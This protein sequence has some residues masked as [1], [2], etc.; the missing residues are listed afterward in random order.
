MGFVISG[1]SPTSIP[2]KQSRTV[3]HPL[4]NRPIRLMIYG[5]P[6]GAERSA[7]GVGEG[8]RL[9][10]GPPEPL[11][12]RLRHYHPLK[13]SPLIILRPS[14]TN[15]RPAQVIGQSLPPRRATSPC[16][17]HAPPPQHL[18]EHPPTLPPPPTVFALPSVQTQADWWLGDDWLAD[19]SVVAEGW[20]WG[21]RSD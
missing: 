1:E 4:G 3:R 8:G 15:W 18:P 9:V 12:L 19:W 13:L 21:G 7:G 14:H 11:R 20:G 16:I 5:C 10:R 6:R 2:L 17:M